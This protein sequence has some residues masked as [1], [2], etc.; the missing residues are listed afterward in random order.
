MWKE[1]VSRYFLNG[2]EETIK[3][4]DDV[5]SGS[6]RP[7]EPLI[8]TITSPKK[9][10]IL[11]ISFR[12]RC[13]QRPI[14]DD[15]LYP[16]MAQ[17]YI[18]QNMACQIGKGTDKARKLLRQILVRWRFRKGYILQID[19][20]NY[21]GSMDH[22][23]VNGIYRDALAEGDYWRV[24]GVLD[25]QYLGMTGY[26]PGSQMVQ[27]TGTC[28]LDALDHFIVGT[29]SIG[30]YVRYQDDFLLFHE[31]DEYLKK[32]LEI[33]EGKLGEL[34]LTVN[35][36]KTRIFK[37][38]E[39]FEYL[40]FTWRITDSKKILATAIGKNIKN[41]KRKYKRMLMKVKRGELE[42]KYVDECFR[43]FLSN[44][45]NGNCYNLIQRL[46]KWYE[47]TWNE[48]CKG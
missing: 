20:H 36:K 28:Y 35:P 48:I 1:S 26:R 31:S 3:L 9:R 33:I 6:Y 38:G 10:E 24:T 21:Y 4:A 34:G 27:I 41:K 18:Y 13:Y 45:E 32:C 22:D 46:K 30:D 25:Q 14:N 23:I 15:L 40:G 7:K 44:L 37:L 47:V 39:P 17:R 42:K 43:T 8:F 11:A 29:L 19:I 16:A 12:D 2:I 5:A